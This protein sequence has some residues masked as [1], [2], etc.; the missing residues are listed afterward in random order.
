[1]QSGWEYIDPKG[2]VQGRFA[3]REMVKWADGGFFAADQKVLSTSLVCSPS[4][5]VRM[6]KTSVAGS[7]RHCPPPGIVTAV[8]Q[9]ESVCGR[10]HDS[11]F[12]PV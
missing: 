2:N 10:P 7:E 8:L 1:M 6:G 9:P 4:I 11:K 5:H 3:A 12:G